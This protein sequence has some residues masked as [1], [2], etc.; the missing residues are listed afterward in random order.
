MRSPFVWWCKRQSASF[1]HQFKTDW[2][3]RAAT[4][5]LAVELA[6]LAYYASV[7]FWLDAFIKSI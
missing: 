3:F 1:V 2:Q 7:S 4:I 6:A 5:V